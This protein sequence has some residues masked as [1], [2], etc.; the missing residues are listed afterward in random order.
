[1]EN[2]WIIYIQ[3]NKPKINDINQEDKIQILSKNYY[4][5]FILL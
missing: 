1:M 4:A 2:N 5:K 3:R